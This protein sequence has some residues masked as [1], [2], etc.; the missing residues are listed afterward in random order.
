MLPA[1]PDSVRVV[2]EPGSIGNP[3]A[4]EVYQGKMQDTVQQ[5]EP[6]KAIEQEFLVLDPTRKL[7]IPKTFGPRTS[8]Y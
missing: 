7:K 6:D 5:A 4:L 2:E 3:V 8:G 1:F